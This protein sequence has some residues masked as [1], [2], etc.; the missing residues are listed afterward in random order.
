MI[1]Y[2]NSSAVVSWNGIKSESFTL[3]NGVKQ[4]G[5]IS[6]PL[7]AMYIDPLLDKLQKYGKGCNMGNVCVSSFAY[8]DDIVLLSPCRS[9]LNGL[10]FSQMCRLRYRE[11]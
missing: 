8:A 11:I 3:T 6:A 10:C 4:G 5:I 2:I 1:A 9:A 7:F